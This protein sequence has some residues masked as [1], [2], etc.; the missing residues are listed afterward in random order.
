MPEKLRRVNA[1]RGG[2]FDG[3]DKWYICLG[4]IAFS[5]AHR[6]ER[7]G[8]VEWC[9]RG[10][11]THCTAYVRT[12]RPFRWKASVHLQNCVSWNHCTVRQELSF[13]FLLVEG[14]S[15]VSLTL[16][17]LSTFRFLEGCSSETMTRR[18]WCA[19]QCDLETKQ[20]RRQLWSTSQLNLY[21]QDLL[22][23]F[24]HH[25]VY[26]HCFLHASSLLRRC[27]RCLRFVFLRCHCLLVPQYLENKIN[28]FY[29]KHWLCTNL[30]D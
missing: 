20:R 10:H 11:A 18:M 4:W 1:G 21:L 5:A 8:L 25:F 22:V 6:S 15:A 9:L 19:H 29:L 23:R 28:E 30:K 24:L 27:H 2:Q 13:T 7:S 16:D 17:F 14:S 12:A 26:C 3:E